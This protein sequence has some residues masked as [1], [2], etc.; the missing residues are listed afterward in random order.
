MSHIDSATCARQ[1]SECQRHSCSLTR[2]SL[3]SPLVEPFVGG[4]AAYGHH[5]PPRPPGHGRR[6]R[7]WART[8]AG[9]RSL[10]R[11]GS[12][13]LQPPAA[14]RLKG[15][16][17]LCADLPWGVLLGGALAVARSRR[18]SRGLP[19]LGALQRTN[20]RRGPSTCESG[21]RGQHCRGRRSLNESPPL[22]RVGGEAGAEKA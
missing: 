12:S 8:P 3:P 10:R 15:S 19:R 21:R 16:C 22:A 17:A 14:A 18:V 20:F 1:G 7:C 11:P 13:R 9:G 6:P 4:I 5:E 2:V